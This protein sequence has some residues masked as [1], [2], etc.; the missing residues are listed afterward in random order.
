MTPNPIYVCNA[1]SLQM[2]DLSTINHIRTYPVDVILNGDQADVTL[3]IN[4]DPNAPTKTFKI[5]SAIGHADT[6]AVLGLPMNRVNISL[7][8]GDVI[9]IAQL[10]GGRLP[11]GS[12]TLPDGFK[13]KWTLL[14]VK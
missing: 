13:F 11:E 2:L 4:D 5:T 9:L 12:T 6:A 10:L 3:D 1:F 7:S 14:E 8:S